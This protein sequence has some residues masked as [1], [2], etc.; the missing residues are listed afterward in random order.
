M[1]GQGCD[2]LDGAGASSCYGAE[3][4]AMRGLAVLHAC[5]KSLRDLTV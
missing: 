3:M 1:G 2:I 4:R 5:G